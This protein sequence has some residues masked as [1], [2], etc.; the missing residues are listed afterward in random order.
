M[1]W[2]PGSGH[3]SDS[4]RSSNRRFCETMME[5][6]HEMAEDPKLDEAIEESFPASDPPANTVETGIAAGVIDTPPVEDNSGQS[7]FEVHA[8]GETGFLRYRRTADTLTLL[9][10][11]LPA[12]LRGRHLGDALVKFAS[13][14][15]A[16]NACGSWQSARSFA[17]TCR[18]IPDVRVARRRGDQRHPFPDGANL[19]PRPPRLIPGV[20][21][22][23]GDREDWQHRR[24]HDSARRSRSCGLRPDTRYA[25]AS[26]HPEELAP[27]IKS[28]GPRASRGDAG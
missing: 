24:R 21:R 3:T 28:L 22:S 11:E 10:T 7:R 1:R 2:T 27:L 8:D 19:R 26:R 12:P 25:I 6:S 5:R 9:H 13:R 18:S 17:R 4:R 20:S 14:P 16:P 15:R 23:G